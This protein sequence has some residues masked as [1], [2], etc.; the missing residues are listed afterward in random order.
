MSKL[1]PGSTS[2]TKKGTTP[3]KTSPP[4]KE[5]P[6]SSGI[7]YGKSRTC[8]PSSRVSNIVGLAQWRRATTKIDGYPDG[9]GLLGNKGATLLMGC[10]SRRSPTRNSFLPSGML[11][12]DHYHARKNY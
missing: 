8:H 9:Y 12:R 6:T 10:D 11:N 3:N 4:L 1:S 5:E 7:G 2:P